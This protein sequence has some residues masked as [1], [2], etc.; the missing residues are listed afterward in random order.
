ME[1]DFIPNQVNRLMTERG[2][3]LSALAQQLEIAEP[4]LR[5]VLSGARPCPTDLTV[6]LAVSFGQDTQAWL[7]Q[8]VHLP[9]IEEI[10]ARCPKAWR[11]YLEGAI[12]A[13]NAGAQTTARGVAA[14]VPG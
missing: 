11:A 7:F 2:I 12:E 4:Y 1:H 6:Q 13:L 9:V 14:A 5:Q 3:S 10:Q 8:T